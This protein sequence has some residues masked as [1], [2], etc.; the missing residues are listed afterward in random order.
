MQNNL[1][2]KLITKE[3]LFLLKSL[4]KIDTSYPPGHSLDFDKFIRKYLKK[5]GLYVKSYYNKDR[6]S[7]S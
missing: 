3:L 7:F 6:S 4:V 5:S 2:K 1:S